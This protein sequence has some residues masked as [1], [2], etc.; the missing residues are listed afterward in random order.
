[1]RGAPVEPLDA[2]SLSAIPSNWLWVRLGNVVDYGS[3][4][5]A[6]SA[7]IPEDTWLLDLEDIEKDTS[8]LLRRKT[9]RESPSKSTK[10]AF[11]PKK[12]IKRGA[13]LEKTGTLS[14]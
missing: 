9:F 13:L 8:R 4:E 10:T 11:L 12:K 3:S 1:M 14:S 5:K 7:D 6:E 2:D